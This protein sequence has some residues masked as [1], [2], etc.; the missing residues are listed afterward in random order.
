MRALLF[1]YALH[2]FHLP[3][4]GELPERGEIPFVGR[5]RLLGRRFGE[6][7]EV[8]LR[9]QRHEGASAAVSSAL[10]AAYRELAFQ[11]LAD[12]VRRSVRSA[13]GNQWMFRVGHPKDQPLRVRPELLQRDG[14]DDAP[15]RR[16]DERLHDLEAPQ[17]EKRDETDANARLERAVHEHAVFGGCCAWHGTGSSSGT[18]S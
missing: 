2:R 3:A 1:L 17:D 15:D 4:T 16:R 13:N 6:A 7:I 8:F 12:Q 14:E 10:A 11:T 9:V 18:R 5:Q